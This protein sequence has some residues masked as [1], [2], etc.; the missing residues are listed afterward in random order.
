[1]LGKII[2]YGTVCWDRYLRMGRCVWTDILVWPCVLVPIF[3]YG[4]VFWDR[5][6]SVNLCVGTDI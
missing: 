4:E 1:V 3:E 6:L 2:E 5:Y